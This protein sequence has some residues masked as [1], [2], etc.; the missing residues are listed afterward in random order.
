LQSRILPGKRLD[1]ENEEVTDERLRNPTARCEVVSG[2]G[3]A[4]G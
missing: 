1:K 4:P 3:E 2:V